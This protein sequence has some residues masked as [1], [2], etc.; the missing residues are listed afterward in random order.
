MLLSADRLR[1][2]SLCL[3]EADLRNNYELEITN[4]ELE[5]VFRISAFS[6]FQILVQLRNTETLKH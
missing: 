2:L 4:Y 5:N 3:R 6:I 1:R